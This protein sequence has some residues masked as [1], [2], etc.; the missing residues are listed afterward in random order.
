MFNRK[1]IYLLIYLMDY[2]LVIKNNGYEKLYINM[3]NSN[4]VLLRE[5][6]YEKY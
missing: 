5:K 4:I 6:E 2:Y 1:V 3:E